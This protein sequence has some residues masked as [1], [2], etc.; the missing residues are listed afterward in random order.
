MSG[1]LCPCFVSSLFRAQM[2]VAEGGMKKK[3][4]TEGE[5]EEELAAN[6]A[7]LESYIT[8]VQKL[9]KQVDYLFWSAN[10]N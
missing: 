8:D 5:M 3:Q 9:N 6:K 2:G 1:N 10:L 7:L 4:R